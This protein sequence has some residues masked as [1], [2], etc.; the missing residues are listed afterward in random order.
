MKDLEQ[1][2]AKQLI[3]DGANVNEFFDKVKAEF[4]DDLTFCGTSIDY[5][6]ELALEGLT[7]RFLTINRK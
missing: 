5:I 2:Y 4:P 6:R 1:S 7:S 3:I